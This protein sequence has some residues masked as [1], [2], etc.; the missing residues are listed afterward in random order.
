MILSFLKVSASQSSEYYNY[1]IL[2]MNANSIFQNIILNQHSSQNTIEEEFLDFLT[3]IPSDK[4]ISSFCE[5]KKKSELLANEYRFLNFTKEFQEFTNT[6]NEIYVKNK[7]DD[8][9]KTS[10][11]MLM[12]MVTKKLKHYAAQA[13]KVITH[14]QLMNFQTNILTPQTK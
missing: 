7:E 13:D 9:M 14:Y 8:Y 12:E 1:D 6:C 4:K 11:I 10:I 5:V 2:E 3:F